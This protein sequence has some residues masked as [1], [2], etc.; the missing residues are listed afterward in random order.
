VLRAV[1]LIALGALLALGF[2]FGR[3]PI[4]SPAMVSGTDYVGTSPISFAAVALGLV[5]TGWGVTMLIRA[6]SAAH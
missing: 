6:R 5:L 1:A 2:W 4:R 3:G